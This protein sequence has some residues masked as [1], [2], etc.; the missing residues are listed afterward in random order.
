MEDERA[1]TIQPEDFVLALDATRRPFRFAVSG[2][3]APLVSQSEH[4]EPAELVRQ[5]VPKLD[6]YRRVVAFGAHPDDLEVGAGGLI[7]R[8]AASGATVTMV[9]ASVPNRGTIRRAEA[10]EGA[11]RLGARLVLPEGEGE[12]RVEG[13]P[14]HALVARF[15]NMITEADLVIV[16]G[17]GDV[18]EDHAITH[19]AVLAALRRTPCD[20]L[21]YATRLP[22]GAAAPPPTCVVEIS[23]SIDAKV[24]AIAAHASQFPPGFAETRRDVARVIGATHGLPYAEAYEVLRITL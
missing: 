21:A 18:H 16:H 12:S 7:A 22:V 9:V 4:G 5:G 24:A 20:V 1:T 2:P 14:M 6:Q 10:T 8:L 3:D 11:R 23:V 17:A 15:E 13:I 19:R